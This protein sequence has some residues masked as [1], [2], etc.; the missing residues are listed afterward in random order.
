VK[1]VS[2]DFI[3]VSGLLIIL[4]AL[5][6]GAALTA[7]PAQKAEPP[8][9]SLSYQPDGAK[10]L[11]LWL[12]ALG[13]QVEEEVMGEY[14]LAYDIDLVL[15]F[16][17]TVSFTADE[18]YELMDWVY[19][20]GHLLVVGDSPVAGQILSA[21]ELTLT[22]LPQKAEWLFLQSPL[23]Q[24]P[25]VEKPVHANV[26]YGILGGE[27]PVQ[28]HLAAEEIPAAVTREVGGGTV[29]A[30]TTLY[31]FSN[32]GVQEEGNAQYVFNLITYPDE[33]RV[34]WFDEWH[35][36]IRKQAVDRLGPIYWL[37]DSAPGRG[38][39]FALAVIW[40]GLLLA[41][42]KFGRPMLF[43]AEGR[44]R[45]PVEF[46]Q[47]IA[48]LRRRAG[49]RPA[50]IAH[51]RHALKK[52]LGARYQ[53]DPAQADERF[54]DS[55]KRYRPDLDAQR[56]KKLLQRLSRRK[57]SEREMVNLAGEASDWMDREE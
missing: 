12:Q 18:Q 35:H 11:A 30:A 36:G 6:I 32:A 31:P 37:F 14:E 45:A 44:A 47:A 50:A 46:A 17:P 21:F 57:V 43:P 15:L 54:V 22:P 38:I 13:F 26:E 16:Q 56:L 52:S 41:G 3:I 42:R 40:A 48:R 53:L 28:I 7:S 23:L 4:A 8:L 29:T 20:G 39:M 34:V 55:L 24:S 1:R 27:D 5:T 2:P 19:S 9:S 49:H 10:G 51:Y 25:P 33:N